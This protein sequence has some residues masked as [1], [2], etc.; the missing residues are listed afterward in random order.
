MNFNGASNGKQ[1]SP[2]DI[3]FVIRLESQSGRFAEN[4]LVN[5]F[6]KCLRCNKFTSKFFTPPIS[7]IF[8]KI[9][10]ELQR[11]PKRETTEAKMRNNRAPNGL[12]VALK[13]ST[14]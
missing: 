5:F 11:R 7:L 1:R 12:L 4:S 2:F 14:V 6:Q 10:N 9:Q 3:A 13:L 8:N